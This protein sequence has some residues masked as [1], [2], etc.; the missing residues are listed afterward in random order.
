MVRRILVTAVLALLLLATAL[1]IPVPGGSE[2]V[3]HYNSG[4]AGSSETEIQ[5]SVLIPYDLTTRSV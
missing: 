2:Y 3:A 1:T 4:P 5:G